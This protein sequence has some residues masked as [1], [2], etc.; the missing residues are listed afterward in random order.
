MVQPIGREENGVARAWRGDHEQ[1]LL[2]GCGVSGR[3]DEIVLG[4]DAVLGAWDCAECLC[5][6]YTEIVKM[7][8]VVTLKSTEAE[9]RFL[10]GVPRYALP[11]PGSLLTAGTPGRAEGS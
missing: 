2:S 9:K 6:V 10:P 8:N 1:G 11:R 5:T 3:E 4:M 7:V